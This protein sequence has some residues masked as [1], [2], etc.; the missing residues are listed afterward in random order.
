M[1]AMYCVVLTT[2][3]VV[4]LVPTLDPG[5]LRVLGLCGVSLSLILFVFEFGPPPRFTA[6]GCPQDPKENS[7]PPQKGT[8]AANL[9]LA[10]SNRRE[11]SSVGGPSD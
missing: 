7:F 6:L 5:S 10:S 4:T 2:S 11:A 3:G 1:F 9:M 8:H